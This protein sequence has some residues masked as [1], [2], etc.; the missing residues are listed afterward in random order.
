MSDWLRTLEQQHHKT[1]MEIIARLRRAPQKTLE[2]VRAEM[3]ADADH[4]IPF[5]P[6]TVTVSHD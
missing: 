2:Q 3:N 6:R 4:V 1:E 5:R